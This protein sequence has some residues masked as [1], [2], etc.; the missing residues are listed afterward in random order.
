MNKESAVNPEEKD[1]AAIIEERAQKVFD[2]MSQSEA[3]DR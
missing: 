3:K 2:I 1:Y